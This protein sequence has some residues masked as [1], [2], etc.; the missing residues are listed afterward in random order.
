MVEA[1]EIEALAAFLQV[2]DAGLGRLRLQAEPGQQGCQ[3]LQRGLGL[4]AGPAHHDQVI[5]EPHQHP[6]AVVPRPVQP[7][8][9]DVAQTGLIT[10]P[11]AAPVS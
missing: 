3:P 8:Q 5:G 7:V 2:H 10:P 4:A 1:E 6:V 9:V 11:C